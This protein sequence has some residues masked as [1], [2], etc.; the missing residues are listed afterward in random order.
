MLDSSRLKPT[1]GPDNAWWWQLAAEDVLALQRCMQCQTLRHPPHPMCSQCRS[2]EWDHIEASGRG[3]LHSY[4]VL[5]H[6][7]I[8]GYDYPITIV[9]VDLEEGQRMV[10]QLV[11]C[12]R[13][14]IAMGMALEM[15]MHEDADGF[16]LPVFRPAQ[17]A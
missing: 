9:L 12:E 11:D 7:Q 6:P 3:H 13:D 14:D 17:R 8:P 1:V 10:S 16:K 15:H 5:H 4:T 2:L